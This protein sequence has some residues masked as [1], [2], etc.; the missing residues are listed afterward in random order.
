MPLSEVSIMAL[1][2]VQ[3]MS[4][5]TKEDEVGMK[6][7]M[8]NLRPVRQRTVRSGTTKDKAAP[9]PPAV[10]YQTEQTEHSYTEFN[11]EPSI[12]DDSS[13]PGPVTETIEQS[14][15]SPGIDELQAVS[16]MYQSNQSPQHPPPGHTPGI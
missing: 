4:K 16:L 10:Y 12:P 7:W 15:H 6:Y 9:L 2:A 13:T 8:E 3:T 11:T 1:P 5:L 14:D